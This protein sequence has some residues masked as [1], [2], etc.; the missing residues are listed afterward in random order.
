MAG[1]ASAPI[2]QIRVLIG[3]PGKMGLSCPL[4]IARFVP[5][6][7]G[8]SFG[9]IINP[10]LTKLVRSRWLDLDLTLGQ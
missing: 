1:S 7:L 2:K 10:L 4:G 6:I 5:A 8:C 9:H 3:Y